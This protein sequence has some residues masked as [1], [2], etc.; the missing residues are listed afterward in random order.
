MKAR[1]KVEKVERMTPRKPRRR[2]KVLRPVEPAP[3]PVAEETPPSKMNLIVGIAGA[4]AVVIV[5]TVAYWGRPTS[6]T[7][8]GFPESVKVDGR[9]PAKRKPTPTEV[10][11]LEQA[12]LKIGQARQMFET[13]MDETEVG[14][15]DLD[16]A[17]ALRKDEARQGLQ[18]ARRV[19]VEASTLIERLI[20]ECGAQVLPEGCAEYWKVLRRIEAALAMLS[21]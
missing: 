18:R 14:K 6:Q 12:A 10:E 19:C 9:A 4:I 16:R 2:A 8:H 3:R 5:V 20:N 15:W 13:Y 7:R 1:N 17:Y 21:E 11:Q